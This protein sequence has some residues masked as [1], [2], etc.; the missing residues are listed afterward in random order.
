M[1]DRIMAYAML[2]EAE[3]KR[4]KELLGIPESRL[5]KPAPRIEKIPFPEILKEMTD[6]VNSPEYR[7]KE[8]EEFKNSKK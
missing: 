1:S 6:Y 4:R 8:I 7:Q 5:G 3:E 2:V